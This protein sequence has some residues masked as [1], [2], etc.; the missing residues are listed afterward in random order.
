MSQA[1]R[2]PSSSP[3]GNRV[4][5][6]LPE[7]ERRRVGA[8]L[9]LVHLTPGTTLDRLGVAAAAAYFPT[10]A[11]VS[12]R[13][14]TREGESVEIATVGDDGVVGLPHLIDRIAASHDAV[15][16]VRGD[17]YRLG[18]EPFVTEY[19]RAPAF[20]Q[21]VQ[22]ALRGLLAQT[23]QAALCH[24]FHKIP[25]R[26]ARALLHRR[27]RALTD[28]FRLTQEALALQLGSS[29]AAVSA[30]ETELQ[31]RNVIRV[32]HGRVTVLDRSALEH[33]ACEC[34]LALKSR[35]SYAPP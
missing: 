29:R 15:V 24:R 31:D 1:D 10:S 32:R 34:Y 23:A 20:Q 27:D 2:R 19:L 22:R 17:A 33:A 14:L 35:T 7:E 11:V 25:Q 30:A 3:I 13:S 4:L 18:A 5:A 28:S 12:L 6:R 8:R 16:Q 26:L 21:S 9:E